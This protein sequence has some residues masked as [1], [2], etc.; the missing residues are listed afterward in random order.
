VDKL[1]QR[2]PSEPAQPQ[3]PTIA[4]APETTAPAQPTTTANNQPQQPTAPAQPQAS[5]IN[6]VVASLQPID[7]GFVAVKPAKVRT[8]PNVTADLVETLAVGDHIQ[9]LGRLPNEQWYVVARDGKPIGY[10]VMSQLDTVPTVASTTGAPTQTPTAPQ[11]SQAPAQTQ[12]PSQAQAPAAPAIAPELAALD[13]GRYYALVIGNNGYKKLPKLNTAVD[14]A[15]AVAAT[16]ERDYGFTVSLLTDASEEQVIGAL[17]ELRRTLTP[18]DNLLIYYAGHG[19]YDDG[20]ERGYWLPVDA[21]ADNQS[22]WISNA[23]VT[24]VLKAMQAK[25]VLVVADSCYSGSLTRGLAIGSGSSSYFE[26][27]VARRART[28]L[29]SGGLEPVLDA[30]GGGHSVFAKAFL[31]ALQGNN[32]VI[33]GEGIYHKVYDEVRLNAE[34]EPGYGNIR[35]AGHDG[36]DFLFVRKR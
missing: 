5:D 10:V 36:G 34:Q 15:K 7:E 11:Q 4:A 30:G 23:D 18:K 28:V 24:D 33:D 29:T 22:H 27:I 2:T 12:T 13:Y 9:V 20:A 6:T 31:D 25:H 32:G 1:P 21:V 35:L 14:D 3:Q 17:A 19:W 8:Q 26:D 16:L